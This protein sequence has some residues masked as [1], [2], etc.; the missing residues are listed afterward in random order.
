[1]RSF[2]SRRRHDESDDPRLSDDRRCDRGGC[3]DD[4]AAPRANE[5]TLSRSRETRG[6]VWVIGA[7]IICPCHLPITLGVGATLLA[8]TAAGAAIHGHPFVA[9][10]IIT[11]GW[12]A[13]TWH[14]L[15]LMKG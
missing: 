12:A 3:V 13:A 14:G 8:G 1:M 10:T 11:T 2:I 4:A 6:I 7:F 15:Q 9:G 5:R